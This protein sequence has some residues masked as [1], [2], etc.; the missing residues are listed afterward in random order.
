MLNR[1]I[2][3][4]KT[5]KVLYQYVVRGGMS[6]EEAGRQLDSSCE[7]TRDLYLFMLAIIPEITAEAARRI[8]TGRNKFNPTPE[9]ISPNEKFAKN[10]LATLVAEDRDIK[11]LLDK[12]KLSWSGYDLQ[13]KHILDSI[14]TKDYYKK[15]MSSPETSL[16]E[17]CALFTKIYE[18]EFSGNQEIADLLEE[19]DIFW[20]D[21][22][23]YA[24][25]WDCRT[26]SSLAK[27]NP[28]RLPELYQSDE[29]A[30]EKGTTSLSSDSAFVHKLLRTA[31]TGCERY[32]GEI[33]DSV[34][35]W[36]EKRLFSTDVTA[37]ILGLAEAD[38]FPD[39]P[40]RIIMNEWIEISK[41]YCAPGS[42]Q[43]VNGVLDKLIKKEE[44]KTTE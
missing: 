33:K 15:Y 4:I 5:F 32:F 42:Y 34:K 18:E 44:N 29:M 37:I 22:L 3:R 41:F 30:R 39:T 17:D 14:V 26:L 19:K 11:K 43:F 31:F 16:S 36:D 21:D 24:L 35:D 8:E 40:R 12:K 27:G 13:V 23:E 20:M 10:A 38:A 25:T 6:L 9:E 28:W 1:R 7:A 2:L